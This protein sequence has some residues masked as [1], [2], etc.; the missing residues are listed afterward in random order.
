MLSALLMSKLEVIIIVV[1]TAIII[2]ALIAIGCITS[3]ICIAW[4]LTTMKSY[5]NLKKRVDEAWTTLERRHQKRFDLLQD[6]LNALNA[7]ADKECEPLERLINSRERAMQA[8]TVEEKMQENARLTSDL[9]DCVGYITKNHHHWQEGEEYEVAYTL[10]KNMEQSIE[11][12]R[13]YYNG[14][15][16]AYNHK[17]QAFPS[18]IVARRMKDEYTPAPYFPLD[19]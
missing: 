7:V 2:L 3:L 17:L 9:R 15:V 5:A 13:Q 12:S 14:V 18:R 10:V 19:I 8:T 6:F 16:K 4:W 1:I 11:N